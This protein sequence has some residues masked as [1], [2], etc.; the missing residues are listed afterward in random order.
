[1]RLSQHLELAELT[2][3]ESAKRLGINN[4]PTAAHLANMRVVAAKVFEP[5]RA[6]FKR[7]IRISSG[8][9]SAALNRAIPGASRTSQHSTGEALDIDMDGTEISNAQVFNFIKDNLE[10]DQLIWEFGTRQSP[11]WVHVSFSVSGKNRK[12]ILVAKRINGAVVY[13]TFKPLQKQP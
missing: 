8:Y 3:S 2:R 5:I 12:Q 4:H 6:F 1:M 13:E 11:D 7:P 9:R 10:F